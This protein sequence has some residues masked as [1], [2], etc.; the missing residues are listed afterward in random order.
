MTARRGF[1]AS[2]LAALALLVA[3][4]ALRAQEARRTLYTGVEYRT[5]SFDPGLGTKTVSELVV[6]I[7]LVL[8]FSNRVTVD[9]GTRFARAERTDESGASGTISG[10]TDL[11]ARAVIQLV[12][13]VA[14]FTVTANL[15]TG[16][17]KLS[18]EQL[19][20]AGAIASDLL[21]FPVSSFGSGTSVTTGLAFAV[22]VA[23]WALGLAGSYRMSGSFTPLAGVDSSYKAGAEMRFRA[24]VDRVVGQGRVSL[25]FTYSSF[26][27]DE[28][29]GSGVFR[30]GKR[31]IGQAGVSL[32]LGN[33]G[34]SLYAWDLYRASGTVPVNGLTTEK[35]NLMAL[36]AALSIQRGRN[37]F[38]PSV[39]YRLFGEGDSSLV[40]AGT[41]LSLG[42]RYQ[43]ATGE[44][45]SLIPSVRYDMGNIPNGATDVG[46]SG[47]SVGL[48]LRKTM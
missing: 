5:L 18:N 40:K 44:S 23:G 42:A 38:R 7:G 21:P 27:T 20:V 41:L 31:Y 16:K 29:G 13:D 3:P 30:P 12:P 10:L 1:R 35:Q 24:G 39:E 46:Y 22:P 48:S 28:F 2:G 4:A 26:T 36:G 25:G 45:M 32:P 15:P 17:T 47:F 8:P 43:M 9:L 14:L 37:V 19:A 34:L 33:M 6:P 11:Q